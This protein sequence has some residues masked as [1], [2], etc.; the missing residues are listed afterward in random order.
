MNP[1][2]IGLL[3]VAALTLTCS[4]QP[5]LRPV[6]SAWMLEAGSSHIANTYLTP[7]KYSGYN[8][9]VTYARMQAM[10]QQP[11]RL[12]QGIELS[13]RFQRGKNPA[14]NSSMY[15]AKINLSWRILH[16]W[17]LGHGISAG[18]GGYIGIDGGALILMRNGNNPVQ[19]EACAAV[20]PEG[21]IQW[22][23][24]SPKLPLT[25]RLQAKTPL[26]GAFFCPEYGE[27]YY[28]IALGN[29]SGLCHFAWPGSYRRICALL[30][31]DLCLG[32]TTLRI[33]YR[34]DAKSAKA[35][36]VTS[37]NVMHSAV[38]GIVC[39]YLTINPSC[40]NLERAKVITAY[41]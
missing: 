26:A 28:E 23:P 25:L 4:A 10:K 13:L 37:R 1:R 36:D 16:R 39:D 30:S 21:Y 22:K 3:I 40:R 34:I 35:N 5:T 27:L 41:Y 7:T 17:Q 12:S 14:K 18:I 11:L 24:S 8:L 31:A 20:G 2:R 32:N 6:E 29:R 38:L 9:G 19:A 33:G 15:A